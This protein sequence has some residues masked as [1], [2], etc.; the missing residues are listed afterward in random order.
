MR[1]PRRRRCGAS[2]PREHAADC[3][4]S[5]TAPSLRAHVK[6]G[7]DVGGTFT[8]VLA[9]DGDGRVQ[10]TKI[11]STPPDYDRAVVDAVRELDGDVEA[12]VHGT[13]VATNAVL[14]RRGARTALVTTEGF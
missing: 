13:T 1:R 8:D 10:V 5:R 14:E 6:I 7:A 2:D 3:G 12:I 11:L 4:R 9:L